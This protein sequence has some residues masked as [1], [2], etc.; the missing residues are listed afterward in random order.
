MGMGTVLENRICDSWEKTEIL[1]NKKKYEKIIL[2]L[3]SLMISFSLNVMHLFKTLLQFLTVAH[4]N[5]SCDIFNLSY[6]F[7][8]GCP[9][10]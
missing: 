4:F 6:T 2:E 5:D 9:H 7:P 10:K 3:L 8:T 1:K